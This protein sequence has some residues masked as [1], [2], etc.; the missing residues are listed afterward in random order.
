MAGV[1]F[2]TK[3]KKRTWK[4]EQRDRTQGKWTSYIGATLEITEQRHND[5]E[6]ED[7]GKEI[8]GNTDKKGAFEAAR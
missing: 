6:E 7:H 3:N 5:K 8:D 1:C 2:D 4:T